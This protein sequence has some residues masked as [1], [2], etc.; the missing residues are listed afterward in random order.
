MGMEPTVPDPL[1]QP[2][3][4]MGRE[5][6]QLPI[7]DDELEDLVYTLTGVKI[8]RVKGYEDHGAPFTTF[9]DAFFAPCPVAV[10][11]GSRGL[12]GKS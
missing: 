12:A 8:P 7:N 1:G 11:Q 6:V 9:A 3:L 5:A 10:W 2:V 4:I